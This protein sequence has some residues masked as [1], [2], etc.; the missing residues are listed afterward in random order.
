MTEDEATIKALHAENIALRQRVT[1]LE[2]MVQRFAQC[3][4]HYHLFHTLVENSID[5]IIVTDIQGYIIYANRAILH[6]G[7]YTTLAELRNRDPESLFA[8]EERERLMQEIIPHLL[9]YGSWQGNLWTVRADGS[10]CLMHNS[11]FV[12][13]DAG[14]N[15][16]A[17]ATLSRDITDQY[18]AQQEHKRL[19]EQL[20]HQAEELHAFYTL[21]ENAPDG[22]NITDLDGRITYANPAYRAMIGYGDDIVGQSVQSTIDENIQRLERIIDSTLEHESWRGV[23]NY[24]RKDGTSFKGQV[25]GMVIHDCEGNL[26]AGAAIVRD[27]T[28]H[29]NLQ[30]ALRESQVLLQGIVDSMP[31]LI[32]AK[33][34]Q[35]RFLLVNNAFAS[36]IG[37]TPDQIIGKHQA[38]LLPPEL[39]Q[40]WQD[41]DHHIIATGTAIKVE[42]IFPSEHTTHT[43]LAVKF[44]LYDDQGTLFAIG[45]TSTDITDRKRAEG[46]LREAYDELELRIAERTAELYQ[47]N[48]ALQA[49][50]IERQHYTERLSHMRKRLQT[51]SRRLMEVQE[52]ERHHIARELHDDI[53]Q[54]LTAL[55]ISLQTLQRGPYGAAISPDLDECIVIIDDILENVRNLSRDLRPSLLDDLG[56]V[57]A[58]RWFVDR[59]SQLAG[60]A[61]E[62]VTDPLIACIPPDLETTCFRVTQEALT[63]IIRHAQASHVRIS[64]QQHNTDLCLTIHDNGVGF[65]VQSAQERAVQGVSLGLL[66]MQE[67]VLLV[68]GQIDIISQPA[69]G[70]EI[71]ARFPIARME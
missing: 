12:I 58:L 21:I 62:F 52:A 55:K 28:E 5:G 57:A 65:D 40:S 18:E 9:Q 8:P 6:M 10:R 29:L 61:A 44:P 37:Y 45:V 7:H 23:I 38:D 64:L 19:Y 42:E 67:R 71:R 32:Y 39:L 53:G 30:E 27:M 68:G 49:E 33:D 16:Q 11:S 35:G 54:S 66:G 26:Q 3:E 59:Q 47:K 14:G 48:K 13:T 25:S 43:Y 20:K 41:I 24:R 31:A 4:Q 36:L 69:Q 60:F 15:P 22:I 34:T 1:S 56:L 17:L 70:T 51:L 63:N 2:Q 50:I 46:V